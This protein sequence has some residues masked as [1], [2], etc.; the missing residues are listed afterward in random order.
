[1]GDRSRV[2]PH[3]VHDVVIGGVRPDG[4]DA[5]NELSE[6]LLDVQDR[7]R[8]RRQ[9]SVR[10]HRGMSRR[11]LRRCCDAVRQGLGVPQFFNDEALVPNLVRA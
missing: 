2:Q 10:W 11:F 9:L 3:E 6:M 5:V 1:M 8:L 7:L 4:S